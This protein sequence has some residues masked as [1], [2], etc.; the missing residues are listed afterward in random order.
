MG[1][2]KKLNIF[3]SVGWVLNTLIIL[4]LKKIRYNNILKLNKNIFYYYLLNN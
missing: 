4:N 1:I 2:G 3:F